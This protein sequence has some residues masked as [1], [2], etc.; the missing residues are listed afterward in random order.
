MPQGD[1]LRE[2]L[3][4]HDD[5]KQLEVHVK[6]YFR[7]VMKDGQRGKWVTRAYLME[8]HKYTK[9]SGKYSAARVSM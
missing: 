7:K 9:C 8:M 6:K 3:E 5:F 1:K 4:K 2:L